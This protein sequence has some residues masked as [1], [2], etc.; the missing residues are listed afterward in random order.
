MTPSNL[1]NG[2]TTYNYRAVAED[3]TGGLTAA[4]PTG[5]TTTGAATLGL[6]SVVLNSCVRTNGVT[7]YT[8]VST[9][10]L[11]AGAQINIGGFGGSNS[12]CNGVKTIAATPTS[13]TFTTN[14]GRIADETNTSGSPQATVYAC[15]VV[16]FPSGS[17][18]GNNTI[19]YW[20]YRSIGA[21]SFSLVGVAQGLDPWYTDCA[22]TAPSAPA[23]VPGTPPG[24]AQPGYLATTIA[25]GGGTTTLTLANAAGTTASSQTVLH[26]NSVPLKNTVQAA[27]SAGGG[28]VY[29]P[30][31]GSAP[32]WVFNATTDF[33]SGISFGVSIVRIH[34]NSSNVWVNQPWIV[35]S[36]MDFE[37]EPRVTTSFSY[38]NGSAIVGVT[39]YPLFLVSEASGS[40]LHFSR[41][42]LIC[43][44][45]QQ[46]C[47]CSDGG[48]D[49]G[50][51]AGIVWDDVN[52]NSNG[53]GNPI[54]LK[55]GFDFFFNRG[56]CQTGNGAANFTPFNCLQMT[57]SS[58][59]VTGG[60]P[61]QVPG[62]VKVRG[63]YFAGGA[64]GIDCLPNGAGIAPFDYTFE[65]TI[66]ESATAPY[67]RVNCSAGLF[68]E[69][70][71][72]SQRS[73]RLNPDSLG[74]SLLA[75]CPCQKVANF[76][77]GRLPKIPIELADAEK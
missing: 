23:Y 58:I 66:F 24:S 2:V 46:T 18:S 13:T 11:Q 20:I 21:G 25:S 12:L 73:N 9:H 28:T 45:P 40:S 61:S 19:H 71:L 63:L 56:S 3:R 62:R 67:L 53:A 17:Y 52:F 7:T 39:A 68:N 54:V 48:A 57:N 10:N 64:M 31:G 5:T 35:R 29:I 49:G 69:I 47:M 44:Q 37:G 77:V 74:R 15:N 36:G 75:P 65:T 6:N 14:E 33:T 30:N 1:L 70:I 59:A 55:G 43:G 8:S 38:V 26:D 4:S 34:V 42:Q 27:A 51:P 50:G 22:A 16:T 76:F 32:F 41:L 72:A 60:G